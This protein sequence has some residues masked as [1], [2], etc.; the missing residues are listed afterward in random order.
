MPHFLTTFFT[1]RSSIASFVLLLL[2][3]CSA[4]SNAKQHD[5]AVVKVT[6]HYNDIIKNLKDVTPENR[7]QLTIN[8][9]NTEVPEENG[10][11]EIKTDDEL[12]LE[13][14]YN[15]SH[16]AYYFSDEL[17]SSNKPSLLRLIAQCKSLPPLDGVESLE[18]KLF[19][20]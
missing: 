6:K 9:I 17:L 14:A 1:S 2:V 20:L 19:L 7:K 12:L 4:G 8:L 5:S 13:L 3:G 10:E 15:T 11:K 16:L 18:K